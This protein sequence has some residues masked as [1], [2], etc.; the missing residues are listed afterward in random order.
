M[1]RTGLAGIEISSTL[2]K[3]PKC[4]KKAFIAQDMPDRLRGWS[5]G[6]SG[7]FKGDGVHILK[8]AK[9]GFD[10]EQEAKAWWFGFTADAI[11]LRPEEVGA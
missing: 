4:G 6:C 11:I 9:S 7:F 3:C 8:A 1:R 2:P 5:I 10:T